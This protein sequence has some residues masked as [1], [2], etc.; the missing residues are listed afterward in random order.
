MS[1]LDTI[2]DS[3]GQTYLSL[4]IKEDEK[5]EKIGNKPE[6]F[7]NLRIL[8]Q[9]S[10][11]QVYKVRSKLNNKI[12]AMKKS[13][14]EYLME[15]GEEYYKK[16]INE[17]AFLLNLSHP[18]ITKY[19]NHFNSED[20][21]FLYIITEY[22]PNG[23]LNSFIE[24]HKRFNKHIPEEELWV[25][26]L[27]CMEALEYVHNECVIHRDIKPSNL[28]MGNNFTIKLGDFGV[29]T[30]KNK[31]GITRLYKNGD[32]SS[33]R[34]NKNIQYGG[35]I[36]GTYGYQSKELYK[37]KY[38]EKI[39]IFAMGVSFFEMC[40]YHVPYEIYA[41]ENE[42]DPEKIQY[43]KVDDFGDDEVRDY[44]S[45]ELLDIID[46]MIDLDINK[47]KNTHECLELI[48]KEFG[49]KY[50]LNTSVNST[51]RCLSILNAFI[52]YVRKLAINNLT[53][54][55][56]PVIKAFYN[57]LLHKENN[58]KWDN[59]IQYFRQILCTENPKLEKTK[60]IEPRLILSFIIEHLILED[61]KETKIN[62][63]SNEHFILL[64]KEQA[65]TSKIDMNLNFTKKFGAKFNSD[66]I[67][68]IF[69]LMKIT[70]FCNQD[71]CYLKSY[72]FSGYFFINIDLDQAFNPNLKN[73]DIENYF[74][75][76]IK[77][78]KKIQNYCKKCLK[79][80][81]HAYYTQLYTVSDLLI[82][83]IKRENN[84]KNK[85][86]LVI[87][88]EITTGFVELNSKKKFKLNGLVCKNN[89]KYFSIINE[90]NVWFRYDG[91]GKNK[92]ISPEIDQSNEEVVLIFYEA[93][94]D[95]K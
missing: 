45:K 87:K 41:D 61:N 29:S 38:D 36:V 83:S 70:E 22:V 55:N 76:Q 51:L 75:K 54:K 50:L 56:K 39:D 33:L 85:I 18:H 71:K 73:L 58:E 72:S 77:N 59:D 66:I 37:K 57:C 16:A 4:E 49:K 91:T 89:D 34:M 6:D 60:E 69:G 30:V 93:L 14:L 15:Q 62:N 35:T 10:F 74:M 12:Y 86:P 25:I 24:A 64:N 17:S 68:N 95:K 2:K 80:T 26:F 53:I 48:R 8:G 90:K 63:K 31:K 92:I 52:D 27:Q 1:D 44:Y 40:Y 5:G 9:G 47:I 88:E 81:T 46:S 7:E 19:Y 11:G 67:K 13:N 79:R 3:N 32:Y 43:E 82:I 65:K 23:D 94:K 28:F 20:D 42:E 84:N 78:P 21:K